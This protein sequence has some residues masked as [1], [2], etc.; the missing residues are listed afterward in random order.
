MTQ[1]MRNCWDIL[2]PLET[3]LVRRGYVFEEDGEELVLVDFAGEALDRSESHDVLSDGYLEVA[4]FLLALLLVLHETADPDPQLVHLAQVLG[5]HVQDVLQ[6]AELALKLL[7]VAFFVCVGYFRLDHFEE[8]VAEEE[9][10]EGMLDAFEHLEEVLD[11]GGRGHLVGVDEDRA[12]SDHEVESGDDLARILHLF[13][14]LAEL[15]LLAVEK[16]A[17]GELEDVQFVE[18]QHEEHVVLARGHVADSQIRDHILRTF[19]R[20]FDVGPVQRLLHVVGVL[21]YLLLGL[22]YDRVELHLDPK[23]YLV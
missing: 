16:V 1:S 8:V 17:E 6:T 4:S 5:Q 11:D 3:I 12:S 2:S 18:H 21:F 22:F 13:V 23:T 9:A 20:F 14:D 19:H 15:D 7:L 10:A